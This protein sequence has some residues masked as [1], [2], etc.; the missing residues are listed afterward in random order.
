V[1]L[2]DVRVEDVRVE[3]VRVEDVRVLVEREGVDMFKGEMV[4]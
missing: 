3:D 4:G 1:R 2:E